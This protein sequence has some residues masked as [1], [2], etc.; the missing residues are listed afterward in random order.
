MR[1]S[2]HCKCTLTG[3]SYYTDIFSYKSRL[4]DS[5][6][7]ICKKLRVPSTSSSTKIGSASNGRRAQILAVPGSETQRQQ[8]QKARKP[9]QR[10]ATELSQSASRPPSL[11]RSATDSLTPGFKTE[12]DE[13]ALG[14]IPLQTTQ[15]LHSGRGGI[16]QSRKLIHRE[17]DLRAVSTSHKSKLKK[18]AL[19]E[20]ELRNAIT[21]LKKPN[22]GLAVKE[23]VGSAEQRTEVR[24][25]RSE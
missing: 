4:P 18:K 21:V 6:A 23:Y 19:V 20:E 3:S 7:A 11:S 15:R 5:A 9:L 1:L 13:E 17:V 25:A 10:V 22:R 2:S 12:R 14:T 16:S 24:C 8:F